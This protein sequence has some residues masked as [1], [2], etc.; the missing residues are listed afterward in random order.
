M[1]ASTADS[2][3]S[4]PARS[5]R[6]LAVTGVV[7]AIVI[8]AL[9]WRLWPSTPGPVVLKTGTPDH[10]VSISIDTVR[11]GTT[12]IDVAISDRTGTPI[13]HAALRVQAIQPLMG[14]A[15]APVVAT[16]AG[17]GHFHV[18]AVPL[19]M[20]G[21]WELRLSIDTHNGIDQL[22]VPLWVGG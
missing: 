6:F 19:M 2:G 8:A 10:L 21:P 1:N 7:I 17:S 4:A 12:D 20:T 3:A 18:A 15:G 11:V 16:A 13:G 5:N 22:T 9:A 14:H